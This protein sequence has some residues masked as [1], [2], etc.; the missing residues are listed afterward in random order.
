MKIVPSAYVPSAYVPKDAVGQRP[1]YKLSKR[2]FCSKFQREQEERNRLCL[3]GV[4]VKVFEICVHDLCPDL[5]RCSLFI[6]KSEELDT[7]PFKI[8]FTLA[9]NELSDSPGVIDKHVD[10]QG[11]VQSLRRITECGY[12]KQGRHIA[13]YAR[14]LEGRVSVDKPLFD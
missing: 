12:V 5:D 7:L 2:I 9:A 3:V 10:A 14:M 8:I 1:N 6:L 13:G 4:A 11:Q